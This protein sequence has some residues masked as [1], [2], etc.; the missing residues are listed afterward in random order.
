LIAVRHVVLVLSARSLARIH[1]G[2]VTRIRGLAR[3]DDDARIAVV[4]GTDDDAA[5]AAPHG[6]GAR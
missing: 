3:A 4:R 2:P 5:R 6:K 1:S